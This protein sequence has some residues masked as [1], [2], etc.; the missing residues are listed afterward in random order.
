M[1]S[2]LM[3]ERRSFSAKTL[4]FSFRKRLYILFFAL[5]FLKT[6]DSTQIL[7]FLLNKE[8]DIFFAILLQELFNCQ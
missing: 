8:F 5:F 2:Y 4:F 7:F 6:V 3:K 1:E